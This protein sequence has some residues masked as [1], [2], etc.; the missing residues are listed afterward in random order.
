MGKFLTEFFG[1]TWKDRIVTHRTP[2]GRI[3]KVKV[4]S[5]PP[6]EQL[7]YNPNRF[8]R[9]KADTKM[10]KTD[11]EKLKHGDSEER[12]IDVYIGTKDLDVLNTLE[13]DKLVL[14]T[15]ESKN[16]IDLFDEDLDVIKISKIPV[17]SIKKYMVNSVDNVD[18]IEDFEFEDVTTK[19]EEE[20]YELAK[21]SD[22]TIFMLDLKPFL[23]D[24][25]VKIDTADEE[26]DDL[27]ELPSREVSES[28]FFSYYLNEN[29]DEFEYNTQH[30][31]GH[32]GQQDYCVN[33]L[34][35][36]EV[37]ASLD[38]NDYN[39]TVTISMMDMNDAYKH[40][41]L[42]KGMVK[43]LQ[44][45]Y[46]ESE[47]QWDM[48]AD[49]LRASLKDILFIEPNKEESPEELTHKF[50]MLIKV[51]TAIEDKFEQAINQKNDEKIEKYGLAL[52]DINDKIE[53]I[54]G[55]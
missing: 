12:V 3:T 21:F 23:D 51:R 48:K 17:E 50:T 37:I 54:G 26:Y 55:K 43:H 14:A 9:T 45:Q 42:D 2:T 11:F 34:K 44:Q 22:S 7:K 47:L 39:G 53:Q 6:D 41:G 38:F 13:D 8:K 16:I 25:E 24:V 20:L 52:N 27:T 46:P 19:D 5:L 28:K 29:L 4:K 35:G 49:K 40:Q 36:D 1:D 10:T 32:S 33:V 30:V 18:T 31:G 15:T